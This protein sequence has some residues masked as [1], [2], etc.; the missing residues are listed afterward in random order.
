MRQ[1]DGLTLEST[2][3][4]GYAAPPAP[5]SGAVRGW[6]RI[7]LD[8][9]GAAPYRTAS[10]A[11]V[12]HTLALLHT[13]MYNAWAAYDDEARQTAHGVAV[14]LPR[15]ER[16]AASKADA[17][18]HAAY[19][20]LAAL[21]PTGQARCDAHM[22]TLGL[23]PAGA[24]SQFSPA[25]IGRTQATAMLDAWHMEA[26]ADRIDAHGGALLEEWC[27]LAAWVCTRDRHDDDQ[28]VLLFFAL[29]RALADTARDGRGVHDG[30]G[31][32]AEVLRRFTGSDRL[33]AGALGTFT[34]AAAVSVPAA[35]L[36]RGRQ[37]GARV[38]DQA[39][40]CW[41]GKL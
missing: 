4:M 26:A 22:R 14:R 7:A 30:A 8:G 38:F 12:A 25:G 6:N 34:A 29:T 2:A 3:A 13:A 31:A 37:V 24:T 39:R 35:S 10:A 9:L 11:P 33:A 36:E 17:M 27:G 21:L 28:D 18:H 1:L 32:A 23:D 5:A 19:R 40:R 41:L 20:L 15:A 16:D